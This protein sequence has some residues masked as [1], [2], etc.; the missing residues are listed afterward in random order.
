[1]IMRVSKTGGIKCHGKKYQKRVWVARGPG[2]TISPIQ[3]SPHL[4]PTQPTCQDSSQ[5]PPAWPEHPGQ[6]AGRA[7]TGPEGPSRG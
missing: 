4:A 1:M 7:M 6:E 2:F 5:D 3:T